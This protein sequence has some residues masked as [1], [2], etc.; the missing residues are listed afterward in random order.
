MLLLLIPPLV[1]FYMLK[2]RRRRAKVASTML[3][4]KIYEDVQANAFWQKLRRNI[5]L[6]L[7]ILI[8][9]LLSLAFARPYLPG[10]AIRSEELVIIIDNSA[11]MMAP[12][13]A[14]RT[15]LEQA[16][17]AAR[18]MVDGMARSGRV[19]ILTTAPEPA[20]A[21]PFTDDRNKARRAIASIGIG[22]GGELRDAISL[23]ESL[24]GNRTNRYGYLFSDVQG[25]TGIVSVLRT[26]RIEWRRLNESLE[27]AAIVSVE[28]SRTGGST[29]VAVLLENFGERSHA[30]RLRLYD[31]DTL[32]EARDVTVTPGAREHIGFSDLPVRTG[33]LKATWDVD[34]E[35]PADNTRYVRISEPEVLRIRLVGASALLETAL[36]R[37]PGTVLQKTGEVDVTFWMNGGPPLEAEGYHVVFGPGPGPWSRGEDVANPRIVSWD[38]VDGPFARTNL[39]R[40]YIRSAKVLSREAASEIYL[41]SSEGALAIEWKGKNTH[42]IYIGFQLDETDFPYRLSFPVFLRNVQEWVQQEKARRLAPASIGDPSLDDPG[43]MGFQPVLRSGDRVEV[44]V[45][46]PSEEGNLFVPAEPEKTEAGPLTGTFELRV[47]I[48]HWFMAL[49]AIVLG[50]EWWVY[51]RK[52][53]TV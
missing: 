3:W 10:T 11:S 20:M 24:I 6:L 43:R 37:L 49:A 7:Q 13:D 51:H 15:R 30:G 38:R 29:S 9:V 39:H 53:F 32:I 25:D 35:F 14:G 52:L 31:G 17:E 44:A 22:G 18:E 42:R 40:L 16:K 47:E 28:A 46:F 34:D 26:R 41:R 19:A 23:A 12:A 33:Q 45:N 21:L 1:L 48:A 2:L 50:I 8:V 36:S 4:S 5:L 27:N